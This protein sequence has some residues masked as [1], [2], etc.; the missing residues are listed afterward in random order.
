VIGARRLAKTGR[1]LWLWSSGCTPQ[2]MFMHTIV[3]R[4]IHPV[5]VET[6]FNKHARFKVGLGTKFHLRN[7]FRREKKMKEKKLAAPK[8][9]FMRGLSETS[10][11]VHSSC[12][13]WQIRAALIYFPIREAEPPAYSVGILLRTQSTLPV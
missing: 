6:C 11:S 4:R 5:R 9:A 3:Q 1:V 13:Y 7:F 8:D 10:L 12:P 2:S